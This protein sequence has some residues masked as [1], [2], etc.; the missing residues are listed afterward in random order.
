MV[1]IMSPV[2]KAFSIA[3]VPFW[4]TMDQDKL[5]SEEQRGL[6]YLKV[7][8]LIARHQLSEGRSFLFEQPEEASSLDLDGVWDLL[9]TPGV[10]SAV[11]DQCEFGL[12]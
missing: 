7:C 10:L 9:E 8:E 4:P 3:R 11:T 6:E 12:S 1:V 5:A 2:C